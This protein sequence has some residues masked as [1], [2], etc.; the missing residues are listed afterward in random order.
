MKKLLQNLTIMLVSLAVTFGVCEIATRLL[1]PEQMSVKAVSAK[2]TFT[3]GPTKDVQGT[4]GTIMTVIDWSKAAEKGIRLYPNVNATI[5]QHMLSKQQVVLRINSYG[6]RGPQLGPKEPGEFRVLNLGDSITFGD[7]LDEAFTI[8]HLIQQ[9]IGPQTS[10]VTIL[11][12]GLPGSNSADE[13]Y[14]YLEIQDVVKPDLVLV[15]MYLNDAQESG[16]FYAK[17]LRFPFSQSRFLTWVVQRFQ[18]VDSEKLFGGMRG[19]TVD[20]SWREKFRN[21]RELKAGY[22]TERRDGFDFE[23]Y[24]AH[25]DFGL[26]WNPEGWV[27][28]RKI[29]GTFAQIVHQNGQEFA[30]Y[31]F[32]VRM[33][34]YANDEALSTMPQD[35]FTAMCKD[36]KIPC[37]DLLPLL[38]EEVRSK[39]IKEQD[40]FYDHCHYRAAGNEIVADKIAA[41]LVKENLLKPAAKAPAA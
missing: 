6:M 35:S 40:L 18:L 16:K 33:Q 29:M 11:N 14:H 8:P 2:K 26:A 27:Q 24:N 15:G 10:K 21:G 13:Y 30:A 41:W 9:K 22:M 20:E 1:V 7:Y 38:R 34:I 36:I 19:K 23:I 31:L 17:T 5:Q 25:K 4:D 32:P 3:D 12:A 28:L 37:L 39:N